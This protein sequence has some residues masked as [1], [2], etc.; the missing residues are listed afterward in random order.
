MR[1]FDKR[2]RFAILL[3]LESDTEMSVS[4]LAAAAGL[5]S[6]RFSHL[7]SIQ[8]GTTPRDFLRMVRRYREQHSAAEAI[9][10]TYLPFEQLGNSDLSGTL[11]HG[12]V[13]DCNL[14]LSPKV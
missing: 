4:Q 11:R 1:S 8:V 14:S 10:S 3:L 2:L 9:I 6:S 7:F 5:S 13:A 12:R